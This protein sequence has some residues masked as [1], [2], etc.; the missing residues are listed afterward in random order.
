M[1]LFAKASFKSNAVW[2]AVEIGLFKS[3][4][5]STLPRPII[6]L[7]IPFTVPVKVGEL[8][9]AFSS[10][11]F[12]FKSSAFWTAVEIGLFKSLVLSTFPRPTIAFVIPLTVPVKVG[13][14]VF[15]FVFKAIWVKLLIG[16]LASLVLS[17]LLKP[18]S[19]LTIPVGVLI[20]GLVSV[21]LIKVST[22]SNVTKVPETGSVTLVGAI[23]FNVVLK[24]PV[25][26]KSFVVTNE[27][28]VV[29]LPPVFILPPN[30][31]VLFKLLTPVPP[32]SDAIICVKFE[33]PSNKFPNISL[34]V[35]NAV[36]VLALPARDAVIIPALKSPLTF[37][38]TIALDVFENV[39]DVALFKT[40]PIAEIVANFVSVIFAL[41]AILL[42]SIAPFEMVVLNV[43]VPLPITSPISV[44]NWSP[45]F[46]PPIVTS[47]TTVNVVLVIVPP[48]IVN[49]FAMEV[50]VTPL[51]VLFV[52]DSVPD[53]VA[54]VPE[55][56]NVIFV[57]PTLVNVVL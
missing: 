21:L 46:T 20:I 29:K 8:I 18:T 28:P 24:F 47:P 40:L 54:K 4:V 2:V 39:A 52:N 43:P 42:L 37:L 53:N 38:E 3:L 45:E 15:A 44:I 49:P 36:V 23:V 33:V 34:G 30:V 17:T 51:I 6:A 25:T 19:D 31:I 48:A 56:G 50:G 57:D 5:L 32:Y 27:P 26:L 55:V 9:S 16:L 1:D 14:A 12:C 22:P 41:F 11:I 10:K 7:V 35:C 13:E